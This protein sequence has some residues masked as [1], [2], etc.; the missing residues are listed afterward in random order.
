MKHLPI[1]LMFLF[2]I[3]CASDE[4]L[5]DGSTREMDSGAFASDAEGGGSVGGSSNTGGEPGVVTAGE[6][7]DLKNWSFWE[8]LM[9]DSEYDTMPAYWG[10]YTNNRIAIDLNNNGKPLVNAKVELKEGDNTLWVAR[11]DVHGNAALWNEV[12][13]PNSVG[14]LTNHTLWVNGTKV[15]TS[16][17]PVSQ[18]VNKINIAANQASSP[19]VEIAFVV[20]ATG[21]MG[22]E[23]EFLKADLKDVIVKAEQQNQ[24]IDIAT[25]TVFYRDEGDEYVVKM[26][27]FTKDINSTLSF[28]NQQKADGGG[29]YPEAVHTALNT[30]LEQLQ[31]SASAKARLA[32]VILDAPPHYDQQVIDDI[33][34]SI[35]MAA[36]KGVKL[37][38]VVASGIDKATEFLMRFCAIVTNGTYV[39]ITDDS[40]IGDDHLEPT[41]GEYEV[42]YLND[43]MVRL[44]QEHAGCTLQ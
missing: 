21:S 36:S 23:L 43:L 2:L 8:S 6:W 42:E 26:S 35:E 44:I 12:Y 34:Q 32:F 9:N 14:N 29:D 38:P 27:P 40:G 19:N 15:N 16:L 41:V 31:W 22:D 17:F 28:I 24:C 4:S 18:G 1:A 25:G 33:H 7:N 20:D 30:A 10:I 37:I 39:F 13:T 3:S 5:E 11:T